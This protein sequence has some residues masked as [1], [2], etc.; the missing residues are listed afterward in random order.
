VLCGHHSVNASRPSLLKYTRRS[1]QCGTRGR[2]V[3]DKKHVRSIEPT[4][5][6]KF[7]GVLGLLLAL[8]TIC[9]NLTKIVPTTKR[10]DMQPPL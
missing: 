5:S 1:R 3:V 7:K 4:V 8:G 9:T 6:A 2:Y 10:V